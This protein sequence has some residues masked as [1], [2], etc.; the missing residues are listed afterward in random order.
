MLFKQTTIFDRQLDAATKY[1]LKA[2]FDDVSAALVLYHFLS[3]NDLK[4]NQELLNYLTENF[5][6]KRGKNFAVEQKSNSSLNEITEKAR[7]LYDVLGLDIIVYLIDRL[8]NSDLDGQA[9]IQFL[10]S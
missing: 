3:V 8:K 1:Y 10:L 7:K 9:L 2:A 5:I 6:N 4:N